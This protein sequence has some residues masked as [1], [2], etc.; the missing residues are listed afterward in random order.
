MKLCL[1]LLIIFDILLKIAQPDT[2]LYAQAA[3]HYIKD[4]PM[5]ASDAKTG[6]EIANELQLLSA[7]DREKRITA[8]ILEGNFPDFMRQLVRIDVSV[9]KAD[10]KSIKS[11]YFTMPDYLMVGTDVDF[12]R[13]PMTPNTAQF[14]ADSLGFFLSTSK[15]CDDIY[16]AAEIKLEPMPLTADRESFYTFLEHNRIIEDQRQERKGLIAGI[17]K[18][19]ISS[20]RLFASL[21]RVALYGWHQLDEKPIQPIY[22][23]HADSYVDYS[24]GIRLIYQYLYVDGKKMHYKDVATDSELCNI[25]SND[26]DCRYYRYPILSD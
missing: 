16:H 13:L 14:I 1:N 6:T 20:S 7:I 17:K 19:V 9:N 23:G 10:G 3:T 22:V 21:N 12:I 18:D 5:L 26:L 15:I 25:L 4:I 2:E 11:S 8:Y 24:H